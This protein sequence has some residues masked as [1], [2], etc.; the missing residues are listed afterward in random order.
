MSSANKGAAVLDIGSRLELFVD[1]YLI[2]RLEGAELKLQPPTPREV[3]LRFDRPW[4]GPTSTY[5]SMIKDAARYRAYYRG[6][7]YRG[8]YAVELGRFT[9][10]KA[11]C[12]E[13]QDG[14]AWMRPSLG[15]CEFEGS[16]DNNIILA[17]PKAEW[18][19][20]SIPLNFTAFRDRNPNAPERERYHGFLIKPRLAD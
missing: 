12:A 14:I 6:S 10:P 8:R 2:E 17:D 20:Y 16:M 11:C 18:E 15:M 19:G 13:S 9:E 4:E 5:V 3:A 7:D 1:R